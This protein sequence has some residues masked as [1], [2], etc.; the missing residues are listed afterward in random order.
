[1][2]NTTPRNL[3]KGTFASL[4]AIALAL[5][6]LSLSG[7]AGYQMGSIKPEA[8]SHI[9]KISVPTF[10]NRTLEPR[11]SVLMTNAVIKQIQM[12]G[13]YEIS[14]KK[15]ADA[16]LRGTINRIERRQLRSARTDTF[17]S[18]ELQSYLVIRWALYDPNTGQKL[19]YSQARDIDE[20]NVEGTSGLKIRP[21][22]NVGRTIVFLDP[23]FQTSERGAI[24]VAAQKAAEQLVSQLAEG[25]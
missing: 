12:D 24:P 1:M 3:A 20:N 10:E 18:T 14:T 21:G 9:R 8:Y 25:W 17:T 6:A 2:T 7:C 19:Q 11:V 4:A 5:V 22:Q 15:N 16:E 23:N 13:T